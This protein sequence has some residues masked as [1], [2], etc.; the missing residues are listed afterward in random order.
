MKIIKSTFLIFLMIF[1]ICIFCAGCGAG[2]D[3]SNLSTAEIEPPWEKGGKAPVEYSWE[4]FIALDGALQIK[5]QNSFG[6]DEEFEKWM[7]DAQSE[8]EELP[9][10]DGG[11][12]PSEYTWDEFVS[13]SGYLQI[14]FQKSFENSDEFEKWMENARSEALPWNSGGK[15]PS[16][17][18]WEEYEMLP[19]D[20][21]EAFYESFENEKKFEKWLD[22]NQPQ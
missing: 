17:Y 22:A 20:Q 16:E 8:E 18:T 11:K 21:K 5:F 1:S 9:W 12:K 4:E 3:D 13:L 2:A 6:S 19:D 15:D 7:T 10:K 14:Q